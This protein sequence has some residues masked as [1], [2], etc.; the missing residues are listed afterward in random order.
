MLCVHLIRALI[1]NFLPLQLLATKILLWNPES[2]CLLGDTCCVQLC[3][4][5]TR[6]LLVVNDSKVLIQALRGLP[7][8]TGRTLAITLL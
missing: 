1:C 8:C 7:C 4:S 5:L 2:G 6:R 3:A